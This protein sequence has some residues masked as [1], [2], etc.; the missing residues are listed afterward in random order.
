MTAELRNAQWQTLRG[1][2]FTLFTVLPCV[3]QMNLYE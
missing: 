2:L 1:A 3:Q